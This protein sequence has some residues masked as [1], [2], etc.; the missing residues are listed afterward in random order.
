MDIVVELADGSLANVEMQRIGYMFPG[1]R[2]ACYSSDLLLRQYKR[3]RGNREEF[4]YRLQM[5]LLQKYLFISLD[6]FRKNQHNKNRN[7]KRDAWLTL[8]SIDEPDVIME[9]LD[10]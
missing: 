9:L 1:Q 8:F 10:D 2:S 7:T 4:D 3:I 6:I 5:E